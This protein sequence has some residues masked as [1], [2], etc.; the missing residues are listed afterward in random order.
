MSPDCKTELLNFNTDNSPLLDNSVKTMTINDDG[1]VFFGTDQGL[2]S[3][4]GKATPGG[5]TNTDVTVYPNPV[6]PGYDGYVGIKGL[7]EDALVK[8]TT[9]DG[10][11]V[12]E[13]IAEGGQAVWDCTT[14]D[15]KKVLPGIYL[16]FVSTVKGTERYVTKILIMN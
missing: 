14:V 12:T 8:I 10:S 1:E 11:F 15:G 16:V 3:Y 4:R 6:R 9:V 7:V 5:S 13:L 2:I